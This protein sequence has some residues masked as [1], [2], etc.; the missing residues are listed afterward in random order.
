MFDIGGIWTGSF[1]RFT[2][3]PCLVP[4]MHD[5]WTRPLFVGWSA[6]ELVFSDLSWPT[7]DKPFW[8]DVGNISLSLS[9]VRIYVGWWCGQS[10]CVH[11]L[12]AGIIMLVC[13]ACMSASSEQRCPSCRWRHQARHQQR[14]CPH[15]CTV[16]PHH[17]LQVL[18]PGLEPPGCRSGLREKC[19]PHQARKAY[20]GS[21]M[22]DR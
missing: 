1:D 15:A 10:H 7:L 19:Y 2:P 5:S 16:H 14:P 22:R 9:T 11:A 18:S 3:H 13:I 17:C 4:S 12:L 20:L 8:L 21:A 6:H